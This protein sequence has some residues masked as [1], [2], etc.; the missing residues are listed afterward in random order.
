VVFL[1]CRK[2]RAEQHWDDAN[3][4]RPTGCSG[5]STRFWGRLDGAELAY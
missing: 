3:S 2:F 4:V 1:F 5:L